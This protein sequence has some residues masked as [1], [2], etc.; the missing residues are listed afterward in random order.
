M[1]ECILYSTNNYFLG[2]KRKNYYLLDGFTQ[3][4]TLIFHFRYSIRL[5]SLLTI[6]P[7][8]GTTLWSHQDT[9]FNQP[10]WRSTNEESNYFG[11]LWVARIQT[12]ILFAMENISEK[13]ALL[14]TS[15]TA[16]AI[17]YKLPFYPPQITLGPCKFPNSSG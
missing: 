5:L 14:A 15:K 10:F 9:V 13:G 17:L 7:W 1:P 6:K 8:F 11:P 12:P 16:G 2:K 3:S 4:E